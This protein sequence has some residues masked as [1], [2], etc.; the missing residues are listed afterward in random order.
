MDE[1]EKECVK[2]LNDISN[3]L[4]YLNLKYNFNNTEFYGEQ[5]TILKNRNNKI[6]NISIIK[7]MEDKIKLALDLLF[8][9]SFYYILVLLLFL[10]A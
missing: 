4:Q 5:T 2:N 3:P 1:S 10:L 8:L 6:L 7:N 9:L